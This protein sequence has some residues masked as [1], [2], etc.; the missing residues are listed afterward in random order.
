M[1][2]YESTNVQIFESN[3]IK[4]GWDGKASGQPEPAGSYLWII[5]YQAPGMAKITQNGYVQL[6]R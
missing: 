6:V 2:I 1:V 4:K 3:D 5:D